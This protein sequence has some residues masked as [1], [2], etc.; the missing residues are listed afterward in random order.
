MLKRV[1]RKSHWAY[2]RLQ[3]GY[4][5]GCGA[6][7]RRLLGTKLQVWRWRMRGTCFRRDEI[8][9]SAHSQGHPHRDLLI[10]RVAALAPFTNV[11]E[12][13]CGGGP[14]LLRLAE[15]FPGVRLHGV[16]VNARALRFAADALR[17]MEWPARL[18]LAT[19]SALSPFPNDSVDVVVTDAVLMYVGPDRISNAIAEIVR[20]AR[21]G[22][23]L[24]E[25]HTP[26]RASEPQASRYHFAHWIHDYRAL[27]LQHGCS[28][29]RVAALPPNV[30][31]DTG[32]RAFGA[33]IEVDTRPSRAGHIG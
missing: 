4:Y 14:N 19:A 15:R 5:A 8:T 28:N 32:W 33:V 20:V 1:L 7:E 11:L 21:R 2:T 12:V 26:T 29:V 13:G 16:D 6:L 22:A 27:F 9:A 24:I 18:Y 31:D 30:W 17:G 23:V 3:H 25:W 10:D